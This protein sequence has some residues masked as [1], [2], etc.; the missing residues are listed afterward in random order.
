MLGSDLTSENLS[1]LVIFLAVLN[2]FIGVFNLFPLLPFDGGHVVIAVY[3]KAQEMRRRT[4]QRYLADVSRH[5][6]G[7][8]RR[9]HR[10]RGRRRASRSSSTSP[11]ASA[12]DASRTA[13]ARRR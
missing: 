3:E 2:I 8:L 12:S 11:A 6:A 1:N 13:G 10:A 4:G 7:R 9:D 5:V